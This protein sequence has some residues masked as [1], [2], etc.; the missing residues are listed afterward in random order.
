MSG[1]GQEMWFPSALLCHYAP[2]ADLI[3]KMKP[4]WKAGVGIRMGQSKA[5]VTT[6]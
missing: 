6:G 4:N 2:G 1:T 3:Q 5:G